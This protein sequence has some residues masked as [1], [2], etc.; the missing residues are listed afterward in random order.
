MDLYPF[1]LA[2][3][4]CTNVASQQSCS[5]RSPSLWSMLFLMCG[6]LYP[7]PPPIF[8]TSLKSYGLL[9][10]VDT[11]GMPYALHQDVSSFFLSR[12]HVIW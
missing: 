11:L 9:W 4:S 5:G 1:N 7:F 8:I 2:V 3:A 6:T 10:M 12:A